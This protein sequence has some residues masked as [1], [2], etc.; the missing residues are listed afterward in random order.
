MPR[1]TSTR[2]EPPSRRNENFEEIQLITP[3]NTSMPGSS[4]TSRSIG[5]AQY[6]KPNART[7]NRI[8]PLPEHLDVENPGSSLKRGGT[9]R[10]DRWSGSQGED[11]RWQETYKQ[12]QDQQDY[13]VGPYHNGYDFYS[14]VKA[15]QKNRQQEHEPT[16]PVSCI[17]TLISY[18][19]H[20]N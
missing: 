17:V 7:G 6:P 4:N 15:A 1:S 19:E 18:K 16:Y 11:N 20:T 12:M 10:V 8:S 2:S 3:G 9:D 5:G 13:F 14:V